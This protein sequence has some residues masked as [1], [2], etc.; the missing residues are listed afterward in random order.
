MNVSLYH[1]SAHH[2]LYV[3]GCLLEYDRCILLGPRLNLAA[4]AVRY[5]WSAS[6]KPHPF[7]F[8]LDGESGSWTRRRPGLLHAAIHSTCMGYYMRSH[9][10]VERLPSL[11]GH[12]LWPAVMIQATACV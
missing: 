11:L 6:S 10:D 12:T 4:S 1:R 8:L 5:P 3:R 9:H 2:I 7:A